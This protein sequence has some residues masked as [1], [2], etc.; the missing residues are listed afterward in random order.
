M[1]NIFIVIKENSEQL[2]KKFLKNIN[3]AQWFSF[4]IFH[5]SFPRA[6]FDTNYL[7]LNFKF[8]HMAFYQ[9]KFELL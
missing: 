6:K 4:K 8:Y 5:P 7:T 9:T 3:L 2:G 1:L